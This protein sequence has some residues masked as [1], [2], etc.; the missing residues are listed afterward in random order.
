M[1]GVARLAP[2]TEPLLLPSTRRKSG[3]FAPRTLLRFITITGLSATPRGRACSSPS[4][5]WWLH[6]TTAG[7][8][9]VASGLHVHACRHQYP[10]GTAGCFGHSSSPAMSAFREFRARRL[11]HCPFR[12]LLSVHCTL[13]PACSLNSQW[14]PSLEVLQRMSLPPYAAPSAT[15]WS[16]QLPGGNRTR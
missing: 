8:S 5:R 7:A 6:A 1:K 2:I 16:D 14:S 11:P 9:R 4:S 13:R 15:G 10:G 12:G 3:P